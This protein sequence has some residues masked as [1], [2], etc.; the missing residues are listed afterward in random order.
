MTTAK[1]GTPY[2]P[3]STSHKNSH[4]V[5]DDVINNYI[6]DSGKFKVCRLI[7]G[8]ESKRL[9]G[10]DFNTVTEALQVAEH[11]IKQRATSVQVFDDQGKDLLS[12]GKVKDE[13]LYLLD[14][15]PTA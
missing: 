14:T 13:Y 7:H 6:A 2:I 4:V 8:R 11:F 12:N 5:H 15:V 3:Q 10:K 9:G 1:G